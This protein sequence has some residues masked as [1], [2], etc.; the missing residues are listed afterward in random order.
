MKTT[1][2]ARLS[3][4]PLNLGVIRLLA[5]LCV[6]TGVASA[7]TFQINTLTASNAVV[8]DV[9]GIAG[10]DRGGIAVSGSQVFYSGDA[11]SVRASRNGL[12]GVTTLGVV[13][14]GLVTDLR[15]ETVYLLANGTTP[16]TPHSSSAMITTLLALD[17]LTG[18]TNGTVITLSSSISVPTASNNGSVGVFAGWGRIVIHNGT[19]VYS[20]AIPTGVVTD[21]GRKRCRRA[22]ARR[23]GLTGAWRS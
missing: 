13:R 3:L 14:E 20:I 21:L 11:A 5:A 10:D 4:Y 19:R 12:T 2:Q 8:V 9:N 18:A 23:R 15:T 1:P 6:L 22:L 17:G 7:Q 16:I